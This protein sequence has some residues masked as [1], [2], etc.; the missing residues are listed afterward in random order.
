MNENPE[1]ITTVKQM[2][3]F[4]GVINYLAICL[5]KRTEVLWELNA[6]I[7]GSRKLAEKIEWTETLKEAYKKV[8][9]AINSQLVDLYPIEQNLQTHLV[10]DSSNQGS[11]AYL[12]QMNQGKTQIVRSWSKKR[13]DY[14]LQSQWSSCALELHGILCAVLFFYWEIEFV[15][16]PVVVITDSLSVQKLFARARQGKELSLN[17]RINDQ[18]VKLLNFDI[19]IVYQKGESTQ[20]HLADFISR[21]D[22][23]LKDCK[24]CAICELAKDKV[25][26]SV[27]D[28][29]EEW[30]LVDFTYEPRV[31][32]EE[33]EKIYQVRDERLFKIE[34]EKLVKQ[35][36]YTM[37]VLENEVDEVVLRSRNKRL[38]RKLK[39][40]DKSVDKINDLRGQLIQVGTPEV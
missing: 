3:R 23:L 2:K 6:S 37:N 24:N 14:Q 11:G 22:D 26:K 30:N 4:L 25:I 21:T 27:E 31:G 18:I 16:K 36:C 7:A 13:G 8:T 34:S 15:N 33:F 40:F 35:E 5:P 20:I 28:I 19:E 32:I 9:K 12:Y 1:T 17:R 10:V 38:E 39:N 29:G